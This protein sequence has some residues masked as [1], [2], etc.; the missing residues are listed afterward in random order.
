MNMELQTL[1]IIIACVA[2]AVALEST[3][4]IIWLY[5][6][7]SKQIKLLYRDMLQP[8]DDIRLLVDKLTPSIDFPEEIDNV[9]N[10]GQSANPET[11]YDNGA[12]KDNSD[13]YLEKAYETFH[14]RY[15]ELAD[16]IN[17]DNL[18]VK[19]Q[20]QITLLVEMGYWLK[21]FLP[22]W[23]NDFNATSKQ[24]ENVGSITLNQELWQQKLAEAPLPNTDPYKTPFEV[25]GLVN[26]L[27]QCHINR[28]RFLISG[29][30]Y[31]EK[32]DL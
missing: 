31:I 19:S 18:D 15:Q 21:E 2:L 27:R 7:I 1:T 20:E 10:E 12:S 17:I 26:K 32:E 30:R 5:R 24:R 4:L 13:K 25:I 6:K 9:T 23:H 3:I 11:T 8:K 16:S 28:F 14:I 22:V 29:F